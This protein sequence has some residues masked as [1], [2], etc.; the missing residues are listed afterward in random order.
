MDLLP[1]SEE[2]LADGMASKATSLIEMAA[3]LGH[4][5]VMNLLIQAKI[6]KDRAE[7]EQ[8][9][10]GLVADGQGTAVF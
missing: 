9:G 4:L 7:E 8:K 3:Q 10:V 5:D 6:F 1:P 2:R